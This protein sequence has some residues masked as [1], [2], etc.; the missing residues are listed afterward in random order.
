VSPATEPVP[1]PEEKLP[2]LPFSFLENTFA[3]YNIQKQP[4]SNG[5]IEYNVQF[6][7][8]TDTVSPEFSMISDLSTDAPAL[9]GL[10]LLPQGG[11]PIDPYSFFF[12]QITDVEGYTLL[13]N[14]S[15]LLDVSQ[16]LPDQVELYEFGGDASL[17]VD[18]STTNM[19]EPDADSAPTPTPPIS[20]KKR[21]L[22]Y[23]QVYDVQKLDS[24]SEYDENGLITRNTPYEDDTPKSYHTEYEYKNGLLVTKT[25]YFKNDVTRRE[26]FEYIWPDILTARTVYSGETGEITESET[27]EYSEDFRL[28]SHI[29]SS[30]GDSS[31]ERELYSYITNEN[32]LTSQFVC[33]GNGYQTTTLLTWNDDKQLILSQETTDGNLYTEAYFYEG[34]LLVKT[35]STNEE[36]SPTSPSIG[37]PLPTAR[38]VLCSRNAAMIATIRP[39]I[40]RIGSSF[41]T[42]KAPC[43]YE[44]NI[45]SS[46]ILTKCGSSF[47]HMTI[48]VA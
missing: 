28:L 11:A 24:V 36:R 44:L 10:R 20:H 38:T 4:L 15:Y 26:V 35:I 12:Q 1:T 3:Q 30:S 25:D 39:R 14:Y 13:A 9:C 29:R 32:G 40:T 2:G 5:Q 23:R 6:V 7:L 41:T 21:G 31:K 33:K 16:A 42:R 8:K 45:R 18:L 48:M 34:D 46:E 22:N 37:S 17:I 27:F 19:V 47:G 43:C